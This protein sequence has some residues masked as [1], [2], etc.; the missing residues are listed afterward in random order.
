MHTEATWWG[1]LLLSAHRPQARG[2]PLAQ[3]TMSRVTKVEEGNVGAVLGWAAT[4]VFLS[5]ELGGFRRSVGWAPSEAA[6][7]SK[8]NQKQK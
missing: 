2:S 7:T 6:V 8:Q 5:P 4:M 1:R 3:E